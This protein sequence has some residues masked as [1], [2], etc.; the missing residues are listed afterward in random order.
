MPKTAGS[1]ESFES[2]I[3]ELETIVREMESGTISLEQALEHYRK[4]IGLLKYC[5]QTLRAAEQ[6]VSKLEG[7][8]LKPLSD[9][10]DP[11]SEGETP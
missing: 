9:A 11:G 10:G 6:Q 5:D 1:P 4:G 2:A 3:S 7:G 8:R